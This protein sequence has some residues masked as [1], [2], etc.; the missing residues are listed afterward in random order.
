MLLVAVKKFIRSIFL[1]KMYNC[2]FNF[3][4]PPTTTK[5]TGKQL[6]NQVANVKKESYFCTKTLETNFQI[7]VISRGN[8]KVMHNLLY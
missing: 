3:T 4:P 6:L 5:T 1:S 7:N 2:Y 8:Y